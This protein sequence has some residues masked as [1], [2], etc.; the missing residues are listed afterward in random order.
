[1][2]EV[3]VLVERKRLRITGR[4]QGVGFRP[5]VY[6]IACRLGLG[7]FVYNDAGGVVV[8]LQGGGEVIAKFLDELRSGADRPGACEIRSVV[9]DD[10]NVVEAE[11]GFVIRGSESGGVVS[12]EVA[13]DIATCGKCLAEMTDE[14]DFRYKYPFINCTNCGPRYSIVKA[15]PYDRCNTTM[16]CFEM[17]EKCGGQYVDV[18][19]RRFHAQPVACPEC[20]PGVYLTDRQGKTIEADGG[21]AI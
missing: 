13:A 16:G 12:S 7:G 9:V 8:E 5:A 1:M 14:E 6:K 15:V 2:L 3:F 17:C 18:G 21:K 4:V 10:I 20:G 11:T 19:D